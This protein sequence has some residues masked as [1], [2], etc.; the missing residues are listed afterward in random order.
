M[1]RG[2]WACTRLHK[3]VLHVHKGSGAERLRECER[4]T[5]A[6]KDAQAHKCCMRLHTG[7]R[8]NMEGMHK[9]RTHNSA[10]KEREGHVRTQEDAQ[11]MDKRGVGDA[12]GCTRM[13]KDAQ[14]MQGRWMGMPKGGRRGVPDGVWG[15]RE[16]VQRV[17]RLRG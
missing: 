13:H 15:V 4:G 14:E 8:R 16:G 6:H 1:H 12:H 7:C 2:T 9:E 3:R 11:E 17:R 10:W 5:W